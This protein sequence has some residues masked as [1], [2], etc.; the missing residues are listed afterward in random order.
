[1]KFFTTVLF[2]LTLATATGQYKYHEIG[3]GAA[4]THFYGDVG[5]FQWQPAQGAGLAQ[6]TL[7]NQWGWHWSTRWNFA[8]GQLVGNDAWS[9]AEAKQNRGI[10]FKTGIREAAVLTEFNFWP[11]ATGSKYT[12]SFYVFAGLGLTQYTPHG[13]DPANDRW[14]D[15]RSLGTEGQGTE[16]VDVLPYGMLSSTTLMGLGYRQG[17]GRDFSATLEL[18]WRRYGSDYMDD[19]S[20]KYANPELLAQQNGDLAAY[21]GNPGAVPYEN[22]LYRGNPNT[23]DWSIFAGVTIFYNIVSPNERCEGF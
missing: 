7:R 18:G 13:Y 14:V 8:Q 1:M 2:A 3:L 4:T 6:I 17:L 20:G 21:F 11:Y 15:L 19:T 9:N 10:S 23:K 12:E 5:A 22:G 16:E